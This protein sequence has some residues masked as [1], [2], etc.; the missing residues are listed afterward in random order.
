MTQDSDKGAFSADI[1]EDDIADALEAVERS[2]RAVPA[3]PAAPEIVVEEPAPATP[4]GP[5][6]VSPF[7]DEVEKLRLELEMSQER[8]RKVYAQL[9]EE[10]E[11]LLRVVCDLE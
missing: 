1:P 7:S 5:A 9:K 8:A 10:H 4:A 11:R 2:S 6:E 3:A